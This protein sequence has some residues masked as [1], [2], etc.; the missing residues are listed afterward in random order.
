MA[1]FRRDPRVPTTEGIPAKTLTVD[2][3]VDA[4]SIG[5]R[6]SGMVTTE[7][8][9]PLAGHKTRSVFDRYNIVSDGDLRT[10]ATQLNGLTG[11]KLGQSRDTFA[12]ASGERSQI[13]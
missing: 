10:A 9:M 2:F 5:R 7:Q 6:C 3:R 11:T 1:A 13:S 8:S 12:Q 4:P